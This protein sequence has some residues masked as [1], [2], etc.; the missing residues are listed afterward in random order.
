MRRMDRYNDEDTKQVSRRSSK[1]QELYQNIG[2]NTR[3]TTFTD[4]TNANAYDMTSNSNANTREGYQRMREYN[5][6]LEFAPKE[7][8]EL[9]NYNKL[10]KKD[11]HK[12]YDINSVLENA[13]KNKEFKDELEEKRNLKNASYNILAELNPKELEEYRKE[14]QERIKKDQESDLKEILDKTMAGEIDQ[15]TTIDLLSDLMAT[16]IMDA[17]E[18]PEREAPDFE[19]ID[20]VDK[21]ML[22][23]RKKEQ[24]K[25]DEVPEE[26]NEK[27]EKKQALSKEVLNKE[28]LE[29]VKKLKEKNQE[30]QKQGIMKNADEDFYTRSMD[31]SDEDFMSDEFKESS[32]PVWVKI[33]I[34]ILILAIAAIAGYFIYQNM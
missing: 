29:E 31:L 18:K 11:E 28:Q 23:S 14:K 15:D 16:S 19:I 26:N 3:Y 6:S 20:E 1:N 13:R 21:L 10:Y 33:L 7:K 30:E 32:L 9:E 34:F 8:R 27:D 4:V 25:E 2:S 5:S 22:A 17:V 24:E 12:V